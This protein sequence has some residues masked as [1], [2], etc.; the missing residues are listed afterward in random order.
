MFDAE[1]IKGNQANIKDLMDAHNQINSLEKMYNE[2]ADQDEY[3][4]NIDLEN[5]EQ[6]VPDH[7]KK[8]EEA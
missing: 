4:D 1:N 7:I 5:S 8:F 2:N 3:L 6:T